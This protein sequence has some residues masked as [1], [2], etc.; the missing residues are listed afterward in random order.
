MRDLNGDRIPVTFCG[1]GAGALKLGGYTGTIYDEV[2]DVFLVAYNNAAS[3]NISLLRVNAATWLV[4]ALPVTGAPPA[5]RPNGIHNSV[6]Y[7]P[8]LG[9]IVI[10]N[11]YTGNVMFMRTSSVPARN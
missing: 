6:Q 10:A 1:L 7:V 8:E 9:G 3:G 4:D 5:N 11:S 2:N